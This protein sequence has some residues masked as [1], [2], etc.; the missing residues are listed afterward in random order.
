MD[1]EAE[2][3]GSTTVAQVETLYWREK[4][5]LVA[6]LIFFEFDFLPLISYIYPQDL[7]HSTYVFAWAY[8]VSQPCRDKQEHLILKT[9]YIFPCSEGATTITSPME[10]ARP[11]SQK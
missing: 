6:A 8:L 11:P 10:R 1:F 5:R 9:C 3:D 7:I 4:D 2:L